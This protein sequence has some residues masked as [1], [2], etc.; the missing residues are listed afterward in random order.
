MLD[1]REKRLHK[2]INSKYI[3]F[4]RTCCICMKMETMNALTLQSQQLCEIWKTNYL[5]MEQCVVS[6]CFHVQNLNS[7]TIVVP[8]SDH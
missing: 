5:P 6:V 7:V 8:T 3:V 1:G 2:H 4:E